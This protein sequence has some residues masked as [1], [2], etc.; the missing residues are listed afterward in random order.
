MR[1]AGEETDPS[2]LLIF[3][4]L[5]GKSGKVDI[6]GRRYLFSCIPT[7]R[8]TDEQSGRVLECSDSASLLS[9]IVSLRG[10]NRAAPAAVRK[11]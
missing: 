8:F 5:Q 1:L 6:G 4:A 2:A 3:R 9:L 7:F 11:S 10:P